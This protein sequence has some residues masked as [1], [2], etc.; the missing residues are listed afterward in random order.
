MFNLI[1]ANLDLGFI[2]YSELDFVTKVVPML[3][4]NI[5][6]SMQLYCHDIEYHLSTA[7]KFNENSRD[8]YYFYFDVSWFSILYKTELTLSS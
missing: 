1:A 5:I 4:R 3:E 7:V 6:L 2:F 8:F